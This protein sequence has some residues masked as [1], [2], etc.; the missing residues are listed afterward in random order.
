MLCNSYRPSRCARLVASSLSSVV[1]A[2]GVC[3]CQTTASPDTTGSLGE[4]A[5]VSRPAD[6]RR[7]ADSYRERYRANPKDPAI[8]M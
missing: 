1:L 7:E 8:A 2:L 6:P 5:E 4:T 3:S